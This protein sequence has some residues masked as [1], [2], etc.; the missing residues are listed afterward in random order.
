[1]MRLAVKE[2]SISTGGVLIAVIHC[3]DAEK[4]DLHPMDRVKVY[5]KGKVETV[6]V[7]IARTE[8]IVPEGKIGLHR[9]VAEA[10][11][12]KNHDLVDIAL[13]RKPLS[14]DY[15]KKKLDGHKLGKKEFDQIV[16]DIVHNK[17]SE[18]E[19]TYFVAACYT[20]SLTNEETV[21]LTRAMAEQGDILK[22]GRY[23][24]MDK[25]CVGGVAGNRT[26]MIV[27]P[28]IG[29]AG[30]TIPKTSSRSI[31]SPAGT[32]DTMEVL[33]NVKLSLNQMKA[34]VNKIG[35]CIVW[36]GSLNL[37]PADD[38]IIKVERPLSIDAESQ[39]IASIISK[40][41]SVSSTHI[42]LDIP[43]GKGAKVKDK[44]S[45]EILKTHF[46]YLAAKLKLK[47][48]VLI[49]NGSQPVGNG[50]GPSLEARDV[51]WILRNDS[52]GPQDLR[53]KSL[54]IAGN[55]LEMGKKAG[56]GKGYNLAKEI[57]DSGKAYEK[58]TQIIRHQGKK[59]ELP[60][61]IRIGECIFKIKAQ[62]SG[63]VSRIDNEAVTK[64]ARVAGAPAAQSAG[65]YLHKHV[66][67]KVSRGEPLVTV[68]SQCDEKLKYARDI[69]KILSIMEIE[70]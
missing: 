19:L 1:M 50:I 43:C 5:N 49:T 36:G 39:L 14:L 58:M 59:T 28:I 46:E 16:W 13:A 17:L 69:A 60:E 18:A 34:V 42:L 10:L 64:L 47:V 6:V 66:N 52:R 56:K 35:C 48:R 63:R 40:K 44:K 45:A 2:T 3:K 11:G 37:A 23:P 68:Y 29:A 12:A 65:L 26:T 41:L 8:L 7:D 24:I 61:Q 67:D 20:N 32:A 25:H 15:I 21:F 4:L 33:C 30:L 51:L 70:K 57:L 31:T 22:L 53:E 54:L 62:K 55:L 38:K 27:V 9:E